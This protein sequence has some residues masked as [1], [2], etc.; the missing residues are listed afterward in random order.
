MNDQ[1]SHLPHHSHLYLQRG[2][3]A[4]CHNHIHPGNLCRKS[5]SC[6]YAS[7]F[8]DIYNSTFSRLTT[9]AVTLQA[10]FLCIAYHS[11]DFNSAAGSCY[12]PVSSKSDYER[13]RLRWRMG[14]RCM[15]LRE[16]WLRHRRWGCENDGEC[17][18]ALFTCDCRGA[19]DEYTYVRG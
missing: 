6:L 12:D 11:L 9:L 2:S 17:D 5:R 8:F 10:D 1:R 3:A 4:L 15:S 14:R 7:S 19:V 16:R 13:S 18:D